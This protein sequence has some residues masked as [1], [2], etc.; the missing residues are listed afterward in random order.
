MHGA[1]ACATLIAYSNPDNEPD[2]L[3]GFTPCSTYNGPRQKS[4]NANRR[5]SATRLA[6]DHSFCIVGLS[7]RAAKNGAAYLGERAH[8]QLDVTPFPGGN[9]VRPGGG[10]VRASC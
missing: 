5:Y 3:G 10:S 9:C 2:S 8:D 6:H 1:G 7:F 4:E